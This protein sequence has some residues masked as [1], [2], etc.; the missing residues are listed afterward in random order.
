M[1]NTATAT[2]KPATQPVLRPNDPSV[3]LPQSA[4]PGADDYLRIPSLR[5]GQSVPH[6]VGY[7]TALGAKL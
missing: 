5:N 4:R 6:R 3:R 7:L 1:M 2:P